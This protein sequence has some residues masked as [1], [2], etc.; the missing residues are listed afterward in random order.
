MPRPTDPLRD[1]HRELL[2]HVELLRTAAESLRSADLAG[3]AFEDAVHQIDEALAFLNGHLIPHATAEEAALYPVVARVMGAPLAT[4]TMSRDHIEVGRLTEELSK[5]RERFGAGRTDAVTSSELR[6][7]LY[8]LYALVRLHFAK[9]EEIYLPLLDDHLD[10]T[11]AA[12]MFESMEAAAA[13]AKA[14]AGT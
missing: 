8:G 7:A 4:R 13:A 1:E 2:P 5:L 14:A 12:E 3:A 10:A 6:Q 11:A 9:E